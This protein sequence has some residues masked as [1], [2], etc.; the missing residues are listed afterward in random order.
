[1]AGGASFV[2]ALLDLVDGRKELAK[3]HYGL[4]SLYL[5]KSFLGFASTF[6]TGLTAFTYAA[7][8][9]QRLTGRAAA[10]A[11]MRVV[12]ARAAAIV[13]A[14]I[15][16]MSVGAWI[17]LGTFAVQALIWM[18]TDDALESWCEECAFG[19][20]RNQGWATN[21]TQQMSALDKALIEVM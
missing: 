17:T 7:P 12:G 9:V 2:G 8:L 18:F 15:L 14:R 11:T 20:K 10:G 21:P 6:A 13:G 4:M 5:L 3:K 16:F 19:A 1:L